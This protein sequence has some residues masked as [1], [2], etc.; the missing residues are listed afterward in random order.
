MSN[1]YLMVCILLYV[2]V[3]IFDLL[4]ILKMNDRKVICIYISIFIFTLTVNILYGLG[5]HIPSIAKPISDFI[6]SVF[7]LK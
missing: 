1:E 6:S 7:Q 3:L 2:G 5:F 4:P